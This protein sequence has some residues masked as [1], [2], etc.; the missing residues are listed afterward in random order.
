M[1]T[2][3][4]SNYA[5][6]YRF[7]KFYREDII[8]G[9]SYSTLVW[10][11]N[12]IIFSPSLSVTKSL[13]FQQMKDHFRIIIIGKKVLIYILTLKKKEDLFLFWHNPLILY[14]KNCSSLQCHKNGLVYKYPNNNP[15][16]KNCWHL[17]VTIWMNF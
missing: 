4:F 3:K 17:V 8:E 9:E 16:I 13:H 15:I 7:L 2:H 11:S 6:C 12:D 1:L 10:Y 14:L 5:V